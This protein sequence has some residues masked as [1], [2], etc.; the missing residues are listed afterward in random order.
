MTKANSYDL[1]SS[2]GQ[3]DPDSVWGSGLLNTVEGW[4][5]AAG[6][7][8]SSFTGK[9]NRDKKPDANKAATP[10]AVWQKYLPWAIGGLVLVLILA[11]VLRG[12]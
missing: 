4:G 9:D 8:F 1:V 2:T 3:N 6:E 7:I 11:L 10:P 5:R 12:K